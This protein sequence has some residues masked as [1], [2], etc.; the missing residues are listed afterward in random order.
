MALL[1]TVWRAGLITRDMLTTMRNGSVIVDVA[2]D[3]G[4]CVETTHPTTH[5]Q[6][7]YEIDGVVHYCVANMPGAKIR[8]CGTDSTPIVVS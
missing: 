7:T 8:P 2:V 5:S 6:P 4:G 3:Q 1:R